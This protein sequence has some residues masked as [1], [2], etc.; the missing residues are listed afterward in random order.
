VNALAVAATITTLLA[1]V[2]LAVLLTC[3]GVARRRR[4][5]RVQWEAEHRAAL[6]TMVYQQL[7][8]DAEPGTGA[9]TD[10][11][12]DVS[13]A[14]ALLDDLVL[15]VL[16]NL[17]GEDRR[18]LR[19]LL[20]ARGVVARAAADLTARAAWR[21]GRAAALLGSAGDTRHTEA[22]AAL[23]ADR[24]PEVRC[25]AARALG[26][27]GDPSAVRHLLGALTG[28][29]PVPSGVVGMAVLDL[30]TAALPHLRRTLQVGGA[31]A[32]ELA[33]EVLGLHGDLAATG[34]LETLLDDGSQPTGV[35]RAAAAALGRIGSPGAT[36][37]LA[38]AL[39]L[40]P[41]PALR[42][43]AAE[44]LGAIGDPA[45]VE[46][47][48]AGLAWP[49]PEV[50]AACAE[51]LAATGPEGRHQLDLLA[52]GGGPVGNA[53]QAAIDSS[54]ASTRKTLAH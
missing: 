48:L 3:V 45:A 2:L 31:A 40:D 12:F 29:P 21:R 35:R 44:A 47:L 46:A 54:Q 24:S 7:D 15:S 32:R 42:Q 6:L 1:G 34:R 18:A 20:D 38:E 28:P 27:A 14:P 30:G 11:G 41:A 22:I 49:E 5:R 50:R 4:L 33:A 16:S 8:D 23:L 52:A 25:A 19:Q 10:A 13:T 39:R 53:A 17:R 51:A 43:A 9:E 36:P 26:R 37:V